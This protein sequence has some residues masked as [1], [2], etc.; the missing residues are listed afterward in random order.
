MARVFSRAAKD[1]DKAAFI[2]HTVAQRLLERSLCFKNKPARIL[3]IGSATG[4]LAHQ[5]Q[6]Q[7]PKAHIIG[8]DYALGMCRVANQSNQ[9]NRLIQSKKNVLIDYINKLVDLNVKKKPS[10]I[11]ADME[12]LP[13]QEEC[14]DC[15]ISNCT[16]EWS[17]DLLNLFKELKRVLKPEGVLLFS[18]LGP[19]TCFELAHS[20]YKVDTHAYTNPFLDMHHIGDILVKSQWSDPVMDREVMSIAYDNIHGLLYDISKTA[21]HYLVPDLMSNLKNN[22]KTKDWFAAC[23]KAY[24]SFQLADNSLPATIEIIYGYATKYT[25]SK[26]SKNFKNSKNAGIDDMNKIPTPVELEV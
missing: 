24:Q 15:I 26:N 12:N 22:I 19:D 4:W 3:N 14:F 20:A 10:F 1:Y 17:C 23:A 7:Y 11:C 21:S 5:L 2:P 18:T 9:A 6:A 16:M 25:T 8:V 13:F